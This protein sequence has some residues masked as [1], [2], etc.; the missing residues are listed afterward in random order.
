MPE[1]RPNVLFICVDHWPGPL[2][3]CMGH[4]RVLTP[5]L[6]ELANNGVL[7]TQAYSATPTCTP[8]RRALMTGTTA[9]T[10][11]D[12]TFREHEPMDPALPTMPQVFR[13]HGYQA[14][15]VGKLHVYP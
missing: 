13:D 9:K 14:Y 15:A 4:E 3:G 11:G 2:M 10:H 12:R 8:A 5:T 7:F 6:N 1:T